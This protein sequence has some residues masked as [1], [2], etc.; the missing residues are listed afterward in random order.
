M[1]EKI[2]S[3]QTKLSSSHIIHPFAPV[4]SPTSKILILG[5]IPS[6]SSRKNEFYYMHPQ[7]RFWLVMQKIFN[8]EFKYKN[9]DGPRAIN[10]RKEFLLNHDIAMWDVIKSCDIKGASDSSIKNAKGNNFN[11]I[12]KKSNISKVFCTGTTAFKFWKKLCKDKYKV[13]AAYLPSTSPAN[14]KFWSTDKLV[15][16]YKKKI[17]ASLK[18]DNKNK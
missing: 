5:T 13:Q 1:S 12:L 17:F 6:P 16:E 8:T 11:E 2:P 7:N 4:Y 3:K 18:S 10:E 9:N 15:E 14:Q